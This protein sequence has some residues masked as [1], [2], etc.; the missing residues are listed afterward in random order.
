MKLPFDWPRIKQF[1]EWF[2][3][4]SKDNYSI[5]GLSEKPYSGQE[6]RK[7]LE[8]ELSVGEQKNLIIEN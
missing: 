6:L 3:V 7:G 4:D 2:V 1:P 5:E 8:L